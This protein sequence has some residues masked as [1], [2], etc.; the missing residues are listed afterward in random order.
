M[1]KSV[2]FKFKRK[3]FIFHVN[4]IDIE[5]Q[6]DRIKNLK[7]DEEYLYKDLKIYATYCRRN[8]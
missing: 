2:N 8:L 5:L 6:N 3:D 1:D 7:D 4:G